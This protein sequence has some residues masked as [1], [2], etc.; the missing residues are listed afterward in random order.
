MTICVL[1]G[2]QGIR[3]LII[4]FTVTHKRLLEYSLESVCL[5]VCA[6][7]FCMIKN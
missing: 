2:K 3:L 7:V 6:A 1:T 4:L 5:T